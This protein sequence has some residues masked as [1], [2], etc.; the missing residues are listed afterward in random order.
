M[1]EIG[2]RPRNGAV[3]HITFS[4]RLD[5]ID[6]LTGRGPSVVA[7]CAGANYRIVV[8]PNRVPAPGDMAIVTAI[9]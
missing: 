9:G 1:I 4:V 7:G 3:A 8:N 6:V 2:R 5:M